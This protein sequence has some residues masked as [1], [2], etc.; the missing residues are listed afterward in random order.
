MWDEN[1]NL[2]VLKCLEKYNGD[3]FSLFLDY[4][5]EKVQFR[6]KKH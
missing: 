5:H 1:G 6:K 4:I 3:D 2:V